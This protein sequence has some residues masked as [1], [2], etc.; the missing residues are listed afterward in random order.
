MYTVAGD[1]I[2]TILLTVLISAT[3]NGYYYTLTPQ[4]IPLTKETFY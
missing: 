3:F 2:T 1:L 4:K